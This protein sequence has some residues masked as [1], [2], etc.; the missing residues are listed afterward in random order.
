[1]DYVGRIYRPPSE[2]SSLLLQVSVGCSHNECT[3]CT[4]Y[5]EKT[6]RSK[7]MEVIHRDIAEAAALGP[8]TRRLF[9]CDG[10]AL[11]LSTRRLLEILGEIRT[12]LPWIERVSSYG[13]T[14]SV[15]KKSPEDLRALREA[16]LGMIYHGVESG[17]DEVLHRIIKGGTRSEVMETA[18]RLRTAD[19]AHSVILLLG[20]GGEDLSEVHARETASLLTAIDPP[21]VGVL[22]TTVLPGTPLGNAEAAGEFTLPGK[23]QLLDELRTIVRDSDLSNCR[24]SSNHASNYLPMR[25]VLPGHKDAILEALE[26]VLSERDERMLKPEHLRGL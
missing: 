5:T 23:F 18:E 15:L 24:F 20:I 22:T 16:G 9:L 17:A 6:F 4:M 2:A 12:H 10:D 19:I 13:D 14:R 1:M 8:Q 3:Y 11:I 21:Y 25:S 26:H 7:P